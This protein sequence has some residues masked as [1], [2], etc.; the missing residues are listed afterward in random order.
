MLRPVED[1]GQLRQG[2]A[3][4]ELF[5]PVYR[6]RHTLHDIVAAPFGQ[7]HW[8]VVVSRPGSCRLPCQMPAVGGARGS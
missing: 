7:R 1:V 4:A 5:E 2:H 8:G 6:C 3:E